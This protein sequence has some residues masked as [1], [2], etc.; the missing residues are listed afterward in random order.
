MYKIISEKF[1]EFFKKNKEKLIYIL[2]EGENYKTAIEEYCRS[3]RTLENVH[4]EKIVYEQ[5][6]LEQFSV[7]LPYNNVLYSY[8]LYGVIP[9]LVSKKIFIR[10]AHL[11]ADVAVKIHQVL[12]SFFENQI[13]LE[14]WSRK[15]F[16]EFVKKSNAIAF[17]GKYANLPEVVDILRKD[18]LLIYG[19]DGLVSFIVANNADLDLAA[20]GAIFDRLYASGQDCICPDIF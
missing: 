17:T 5:S 3:L 16:V 14:K 20:N 7:Y 8:V 9:S 15:E 4:L 1:I 11:S 2:T 6:L 19:G 12:G 13:F 18:Q 10:P